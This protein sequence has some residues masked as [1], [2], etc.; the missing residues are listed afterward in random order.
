MAVAWKSIVGLSLVLILV[1]G[2][3]FAERGQQPQPQDNDAAAAPAKAAPAPPGPPGK[4]GAPKPDAAKINTMALATLLRAKVPVIILDARRDKLAGAS[5]IPGAKILCARST[6]AEVKAAV[7]NKTAL[8]V[9]YGAGT[10]C[11]AGP[12]LAE[13]LRK[14][15]YKN[16]LEYPEGADG[17]AAA[18]MPGK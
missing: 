8:I 1:A 13:H 5:C 18:G 6:A 16:V 17:W 12:K 10:K 2:V 7:P 4:P 14:L 9:T 11:A 3:A 15:G